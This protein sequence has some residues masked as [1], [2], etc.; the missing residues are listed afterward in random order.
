MTPGIIKIYP[1]G[2]KNGFGLKLQGILPEYSRKVGLEYNNK[3]E[4]YSPNV[5]NMVNSYNTFF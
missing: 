2:T 5:V 4:E 1:P 3:E